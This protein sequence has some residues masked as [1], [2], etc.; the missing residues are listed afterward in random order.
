[1]ESLK[2]TV[3][4]LSLILFTSTLFAQES[5][6]RILIN[7]I[8]IFNGKDNKVVKGNILIEGKLIK[9]VSSSPIILGESVNTQIIDGNG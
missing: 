4:F 8:N 5:P 3:L 9:T 2:K 6:D 1:M 7:N